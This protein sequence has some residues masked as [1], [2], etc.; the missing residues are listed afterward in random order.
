M[1]HFLETMLFSWIIY[2]Y[3]RWEEERKTYANS[4]FLSI[5]FSFEWPAIELEFSKQ[6][7]MW[8]CK[9]CNVFYKTITS[10]SN[11]RSSAFRP[12]TFEISDFFMVF[13]IYCTL[14]VVAISIHRSAILLCMQK[15]YVLVS[16][17][18]FN[19]C[20]CGFATIYPCEAFKYD[21]TLKGTN[22]TNIHLYIYLIWWSRSEVICFG[23]N[24]A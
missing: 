17:L 10:D 15:I 12:M 13:T 11:K 24:S 9:I 14:F 16:N 23:Q 3:T 21:F 7:D 5:H 18:K 1:I 20:A 19:E 6:C 8:C 2:I 4:N 22:Y